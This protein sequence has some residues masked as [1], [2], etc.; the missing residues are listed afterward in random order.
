MGSSVRQT[1]KHGVLAPLRPS[2]VRTARTATLQRARRPAKL[3][4]LQGCEVVIVSETERNK[5]LTRAFV[6]AIGRGD[7]EAILESYAEDGRVITMGRTLISGTYPKAQIAALAGQ[8]LQAFPQGL[9][10]TIHAL[11]AEEDRVAV[12]AESSGPHVSGRHYHNHYHFLFRWR[13]GK[14]VELREYMDTELV[15]DILCGGARPP[16]AESAA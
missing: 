15:T 6:D 1:D 10:F 3:R 8:V 7:T 11:T 12:M 4:H 13:D 2:S 9:E 14:L 16:H 5:A